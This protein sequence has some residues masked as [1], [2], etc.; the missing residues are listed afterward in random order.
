MPIRRPEHQ[1]AQSMSHRRHRPVSRIAR[2]HRQHPREAA[3][4]EPRLD[5]D[6]DAD[7]DD[8]HEAG[9]RAQHPTDRRGDATQPAHGLL[10]EL[11]HLH[12]RRRQ[13]I[14]RGKV[15]QPLRLD[16]DELPK[17]LRLPRQLH[18]GKPNRPDQKRHGEQRHDPQPPPAAD[19]QHAPQ[20][21]RPAVQHRGK[22][23]ARDD[24]QQRLGQQDHRRHQQDRAEPHGYALQLL[25]DHRVPHLDRA[26]PLYMHIRFAV[27]ILGRA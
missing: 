7:H 17:G 1:V 19:R 6:E 5:R 24:Q 12:A 13:A 3:L 4:V 21:P 15:H 23:D 27:R 16:R 22:D 2:G 14:G 25:P 8:H 26:G 11:I 20:Q 9:E 10:R 18:A